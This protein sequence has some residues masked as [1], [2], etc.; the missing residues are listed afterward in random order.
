MSS[1]GDALVEVIPH[2]RRYALAL[3]RSRHAAD[4]LVQDALLRAMERQGQFQQGTNLRAWAFTIMH[5]VFVDQV[6]RSVLLKNDSWPTS[7]RQPQTVQGEQDA[8]IELRELQSALDRLPLMQRSLLLL[9]GL[10]GFSYEEAAEVTGVA[11]G[12]V[13]SRLSRARE[14]L[15]RETS[16]PNEGQLGEASAA[17]GQTGRSERVLGCTAAF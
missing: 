17:Q 15:R 5:N 14:A 16:D 8:C 9:I 13:K 6:R 11:I 12:T 2:L 10:E 1:F 3:T 7:E 4:D